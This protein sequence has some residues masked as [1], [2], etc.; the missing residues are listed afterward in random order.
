LN[1]STIYTGK[2]PCDSTEILGL[3]FGHDGFP[4]PNINPNVRVSYGHIGVI[5]PTDSVGVIHA[6]WF[7]DCAPAGE[8]CISIGLGGELASACVAVKE[9]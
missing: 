1:P 9:K 2:P 5:F 6:W 4:I 7:L 8:Y 3:V